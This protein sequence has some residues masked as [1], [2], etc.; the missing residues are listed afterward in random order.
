MIAVRARP[1]VGADLRPGLEDLVNVPLP[2]ADGKD[3][4]LRQLPRHLLRAPITLHPA[5]TLLLLDRQMLARLPPL[6]KSS[7]RRARKAV[8]EQSQRQ[9]RFA[10]HIKRVHEKP[11]A[12]LLIER[13]ATLH[14]LH[15][16]K[17]DLGARPPANLPIPFLLLGRIPG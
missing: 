13:A 16:G 11:A 7:S 3:L 4:A 1:P 15:V 2:V 8:S 10:L 5:E 17:V 6:R 9:A 14:R 12:G